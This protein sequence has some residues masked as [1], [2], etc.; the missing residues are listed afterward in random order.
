MSHLAPNWRCFQ[1]V[2]SGAEAS[3]FA[4]CCLFSLATLEV[5]CDPAT[6]SF[7]L[8]EQEQ[9]GAWRWAVINNCGVVLH[10][11]CECTQLEAK[12]SASAALYD[13][14]TLAIAWPWAT[15]RGRAIQ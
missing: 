5:D 6:K 14:S 15:L 7:A 8:T 11:G 13:F 10:D 1:T 12:K 4:E 2:P 3:S 9:P